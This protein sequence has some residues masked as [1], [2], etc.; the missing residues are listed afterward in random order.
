MDAEFWGNSV[1]Q[2]LLAGAVSGGAFLGLVLL[3]YVLVVRLGAV[4]KR[5]T[6]T[7]DD[8][9]VDV[10]GR[11]RAV[12][13]AVAGLWVGASSLEM[14]AS[15]HAIMRVIM[16]VAIA[17]QAA[18]WGSAAISG[19]LGVRA[20]RVQA[21]DPAGATTLNALGMVARLALYSVVVLF[22]LDNLGMNV[23]AL[24]TGLG[25]GGVA[26]A[27]ATQNILGDLL[28]S[29]SIVL[30]KPFVVG[31]FIVVGDLMGSIEHVGLKTTRVRSLWGEQ[32]I[33]A[34]AD[35]LGSRIRNFKRMSERRVAFSIGVT[36][37]TPR[38]SLASIPGLIREIICADSG[39]RF[40]RA[41]FKSYDDSALTFEAVY[42]VLDPD[43][44]RFMDIQQ[45]INFGL[46]ER[47]A[48]EGIE[49]AYPTRTVY[50]RHEEADA[51]SHVT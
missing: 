30:D 8:I 13:L 1:R 37:Q 26:I 22:T 29:L 20:R 51:A 40:D 19:A 23:S 43:Y 50:L 32:L 5:T 9:L 15:H 4:A 10:V 25:I 45:R 31:D 6:N 33:F 21:E 38:A 3:R 44:N 41:H 39:V 14:A 27:L 46:F 42:F 28:A 16:V 24:V 48:Q 18:V 35:L 11:T 36:Y 17:V 12:F 49:F 7:F 47:F 34:N 2:W